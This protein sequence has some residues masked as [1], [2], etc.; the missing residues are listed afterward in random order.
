MR[1]PRRLAMEQR[2]VPQPAY[3]AQA[4]LPAIR[5]LPDA[6]QSSCLHSPIVAQASL[7]AFPHRIACQLGALSW[8]NPGLASMRSFRENW[9]LAR[10]NELVRPISP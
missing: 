8:Q 6:E 1:A 10:H 3:V 5:H 2:I 7:P 4:S 9:H